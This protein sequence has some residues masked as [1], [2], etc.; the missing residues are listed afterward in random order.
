MFYIGVITVIIII[1]LAVF[2]KVNVIGDSM[3]PT[4]KNGESVRAIR[5]AYFFPLV[6]GAVYV[7]RSPSG[8][9]VIKRLDHLKWDDP[10]MCYFV[11][12]NSSVSYDSRNYGYVYRYHIIGMVLFS[13]KKGEV[14]NEQRKGC[15]AYQSEQ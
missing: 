15:L 4:Y 6:V 5:I 11:G 3:Y 1:L 10:T 2:P 13:R 7:F 8:D 9:I 12:D 14:K